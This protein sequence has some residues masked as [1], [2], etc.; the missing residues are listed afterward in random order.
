MQYVRQRFWIVAGRIL[1]RQ[2][3][4]QCVTCRLHRKES[5]Q[6]FMADLPAVRARVANPFENCGLAYAGPMQIKFGRN[7]S[8]AAY[9]AVFVCMAYKAVH[10]EVGDL[11]SEAFIAALERFIAMRGGNVRHINSDNGRTFVGANRLLKKSF[12]QWS[13]KEVAQHLNLQG[14]QWHFIT[15]AAPHHGGLWEAT[16]KSTKYHLRRVENQKFTFVELTTLMA[17]IAIVCN[18]IN[19]R[20]FPEWW[21]DDS[22]TSRLL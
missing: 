9:I 7:Q 10:L 11:M 5:L 19:P 4:Q 3:C 21:A 6:Q 13:Q 18:G 17:K 12:A 1:I 20:A 2:T 8:R 15:P 16:V 22:T 14:I